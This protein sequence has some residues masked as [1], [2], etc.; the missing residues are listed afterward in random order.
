MGVTVASIVFSIKALKMSVVYKTGRAWSWAEADPEHFPGWAQCPLC[1]HNVPG[2][3]SSSLGKI[4]FPLTGF[5]EWFFI[6][7]FFPNR[8]T[9]GC[10]KVIPQFP[11]LW[12]KKTGMTFMPL[13]LVLGSRPLN[14]RRIPRRRP[15]NRPW[16]RNARCAKA[17]NK[18][19]PFIVVQT[20]IF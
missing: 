14:S 20:V 7:V 16:E 13:L 8:G 12:V 15:M 1:A 10:S 4:A 18:G 5:V 11:I 17:T 2:I 3:Q 9:W 19:E 6:M